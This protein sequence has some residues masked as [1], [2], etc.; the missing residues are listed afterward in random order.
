MLSWR[1][2]LRRATRL[3]NLSCSLVRTGA[4]A[5]QD[6]A[7]NKLREERAKDSEARS[8]IVQDQEHVCE[9]EPRLIALALQTPIGPYDTAVSTA[10]TE[11]DTTALLYRKEQELLLGT[12]H[13]RGMQAH[14][15]R[16]VLTLLPSTRSC[17]TN[18]LAGPA[19]AG[20]EPHLTT[21]RSY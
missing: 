9:P 18:E 10:P 5:N 11:R 7:T 1:T 20:H 19:A 13:S 2:K 8:R 14:S 21:P 16:S 15:A 4:G 6:Q 3:M 17:I 12:I